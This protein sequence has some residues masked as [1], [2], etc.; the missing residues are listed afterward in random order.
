MRASRSSYDVAVVGA[1][2]VGSATAIAFARR[3]AK[4][5]L[6]EA[7]PRAARRFAGE[8]LHPTGVDVLDELRVGRLDGASAR[9][10]YGFVIFPDDRSAPIEMPYAEGQGDR[11]GAMGLDTTDLNTLT[12]LRNAG[13]PVVVVLVS[14][15]PLDIASQISNWNALV[16][17]WRA[18]SLLAPPEPAKSLAPVER[19]AVVSGSCSPI[20]ATQIERAEAVGFE[21]IDLDPHDPDWTGDGTVDISDPVSLLRHLFLGGAASPCAAAGDADD[22]GSLDLTDAV[23]VLDHLFQ[24]GPPPASPFPSC[25]IDPTPDALG[26]EPAARCIR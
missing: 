4:V 15:R 10:G 19:L 12:T 25:G 11:T 8:W 5:V 3:G 2:P 9:T 14:G 24:G 26:C 16:A 7:D 17:A 20:T 13:V 23:L 6:L 18:A 21:V 1:G 22:G